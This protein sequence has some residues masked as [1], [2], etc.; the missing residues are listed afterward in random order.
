MAWRTWTYSTDCERH[1]QA[2]RDACRIGGASCLNSLAGSPG[3]TDLYSFFRPCKYLSVVPK[4]SCSSIMRNGD[5]MPWRAL[6]PPEL[7]VL[8][9]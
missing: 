6:S 5:R 3:E 1:L 2:R 4:M 7:T 8:K 9:T